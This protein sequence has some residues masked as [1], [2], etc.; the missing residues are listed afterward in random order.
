[1]SLTQRANNPTRLLVVDDEP[2]LAEL[3]V[4]SLTFAGYEVSV[5]RTGSEALNS[6]TEYQPALIILD[7]NLPDFNGFVVAARLR[8]G[9]D[10]TPIIFLTARDAPTDLRDGFGA[11]G[12]DY[13]TKPFR[14]EELRLR[15]DAVLRRTLTP[16]A[17]DS[18]TL[19]VADLVVDVD[20][21]RAWRGNVPIE[22]STIEFSLLRHLATHPNKVFSTADLSRHAWGSD[23]KADA[24]TVHL[25]MSGL[26]RKV[27][28]PGQSMI[29]TVADLGYV[30]RVPQH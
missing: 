7:V 9:G 29:D 18:S 23:S 24:S 22:L 8:A 27:N 1:M 17:G 4:D 28:R 30:M 13:L 19:K 15:I 20:G 11:G 3:L 14:L 26:R 2:V 25:G 16:T 6:V 10:D 12:D 5:A 21:R